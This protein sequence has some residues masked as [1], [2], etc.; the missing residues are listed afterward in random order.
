MFDDAC[1]H[2]N[3]RHLT[4][5]AVLA[6]PLL[7]SACASEIVEAPTGRS[8]R[9]LE[10]ARVD[11]AQAVEWLNAYRAKG[12]LAAVRIDE[13]LMA[14]A[15]A[16]AQ[17]MAA[18]DRMSHDVKGNFAG[19]LA[20]AGVRAAEAGENICAGYYST[21]EAM[22]AWRDSP[23]H[24]ANLRM[25]SATRFGIALGKNLH[26]RFGRLLGHGYRLAAAPDGLSLTLADGRL[27]KLKPA[28]RCRWPCRLAS[29]TTKRG[30]ATP[31]W[32]ADR[33]RAPADAWRRNG[34]TR[35]ASR[36]QASP[37]RRAF[38]PSP[39]A[40][41]AARAVPP[42]RLRNSGPLGFRV[43]GQTAI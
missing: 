29:S 34:A 35:A 23:E 33:R 31:G 38:A 26:S 24:D 13:E 17:A 9:A 15:L 10:A 37:R 21:Q 7:L 18:A 22:V 32:C 42:W 8:L 5:R 4:R 27:C 14:I 30:P 40:R 28:A 12:G 39:V 3:L 25:R 20:D 41:C 11:P 19:R 1:D 16:Q 43:Q 36:C 6:A 2:R